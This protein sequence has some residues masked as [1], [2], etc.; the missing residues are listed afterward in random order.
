MIEILAVIVP[1]FGLTAI[2]FAA[3]RLEFITSEGLAGLRRFLLDLALPALIFQLVAEAPIGGTNLVVFA[4]T[5]TFATYCAFAI[6][7]SIA[8]LLNR[9]NVP[10]ATVEG[11]A[12]SHAD[13]ALM[14]PALAIGAFG[15]AAAAPLALVL[16]VDGAMLAALT[17][18]MLALGGS[19]RSEPAALTQRVARGVLL[20]PLLVA[21]LVGLAANALRIHLP[22]PVDALLTLLRQAAPA[23]ALFAL[24][25]GLPFRPIESFDPE[26]PLLLVVKLIIHPLIVYLLLSW[27]GGFDPV[28][29]HTAVLMAAL[30]PTAGVLGLAK[31]YGADIERTASTVLLATAASIATVTVV[32]VLLLNDFL[33]VQPFR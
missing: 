31:E 4:L 16:A 19:G 25:A 5:A 2:G 1:V 33:P 18:L 29:V 23:V 17:P 27:V 12:G 20:N 24:G 3:A 9:G 21:T 11:L 26:V 6:A 14:G 28:W 22:A 32:L 30:P 15:I 13:V 10:E 7:F 8:A